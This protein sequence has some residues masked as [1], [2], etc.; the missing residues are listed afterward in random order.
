MM[1]CPICGQMYGAVPAL[2]RKDSRTKIC[3]ICATREA[4]DAAGITD[5]N[6]LRGN[7]LAAVRKGYAERGILV[8]EPGATA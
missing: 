7:V 1:A 8:P 4:L 2:S 3:P 6:G 5:K